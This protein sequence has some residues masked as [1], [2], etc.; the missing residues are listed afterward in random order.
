MGVEKVLLE[1]K[2]HTIFKDA[3][4]AV[5]LPNISN[6]STIVYPSGVYV[7]GPYFPR[8]GKWLPSVAKAKQ[9]ID[10]AIKMRDRQVGG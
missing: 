8:T 1:Y 4:L 2:G 3:L 7:S 5:N 9:A 6:E 10:I